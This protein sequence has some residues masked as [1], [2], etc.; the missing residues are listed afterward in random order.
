VKPSRKR[1]KREP[2]RTKEPRGKGAPLLLGPLFQPPNP[3]PESTLVHT[4]MHVH[5]MC[6]RVQACELALSLSLSLCQE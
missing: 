6:Q 1:R 5:R 3:A 4:L 2:P